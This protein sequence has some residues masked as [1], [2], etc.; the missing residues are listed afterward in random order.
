MTSPY[1]RALATPGAPGFV[2]AAFVGRLPIAMVGIG[3]ILLVQARTGSY[4]IAGA[5]AA[6]AALAEA[7][8]APLVGRAL[9]RLGQARVLIICL[10]LHIAAMGGLV[11]AVRAGAPEPTWFVGAAVC[12]AAM[13]PVGACVRS[14]WTSKLAGD[15]LLASALALESAIDELV[16]MVGPTIITLLAAAVSPVA[17][18]AAAATFGTVGVLTLVRQ[19]ATDPGPSQGGPGARIR[20]LRGQATR[21]LVLTF[22][23]TGAAFGGLD[24]SMVA[25][26]RAHHAGAVGG[27]LLGLVALGSG[28]GGL[29][30][31]ARSHRR[32]LETR[33]R[34]TAGCMAVGL[35]IPLLA[36]GVLVMTPLAVASGLAIAP[37]LINGYG[38]VERLVPPAARTEGFA[39][40]T[41]AIATGVA[42]GSPLAG[43]LI[44]ASTPRTGF[45]VVAGCGTLAAAVAAS[46]VVTRKKP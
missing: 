26:S 28:V 21:R 3:T 13:P 16:F 34:L 31:G 27:A 33:F 1:R 4:G 5:V 7:T 38:L 41:T 10:T 15:P 2:A 46:D 6:G 36:P 22:L 37:A 35:C 29:V 30:Y 9:D 17:G 14:R 8:A 11:V 42:L 43:R 40:L 44:D 18:L 39:W 20:M 23:A 45:V 25:F 24:V 19:R 32:V 12:G